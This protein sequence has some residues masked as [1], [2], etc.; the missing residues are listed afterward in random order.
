MSLPLINK[1]TRARVLENRVWEV[2]LKR[3]RSRSWQVVAPDEET[4]KAAVLSHESHLDFDDLSV[5]VY[6]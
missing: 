6:P 5:A 2:A 1:D 4:A 3:N